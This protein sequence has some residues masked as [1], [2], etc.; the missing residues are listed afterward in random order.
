MRKKYFFR[1]FFLVIILVSNGIGSGVQSRKNELKGKLKFSDWVR[2]SKE[3]QQ[4]LFLRFNFPEIIGND[5]TLQYKTEIFDEFTIYTVGCFTKTNKKKKPGFEDVVFTVTVF[6]DI[7]TARESV[8][9]LLSTFSAPIEYLDKEWKDEKASHGDKAFGKNLWCM[10]NAVIRRGNRAYD[11]ALVASVFNRFENYFRRKSVS[12]D[13][14]ILP[15]QGNAGDGVITLD[16]FPDNSTVFITAPAE[17]DLTLGLGE[18]NRTLKI[19]DTDNK[20]TF[21]INDIHVNTVRVKE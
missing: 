21:N 11:E 17:Y 6:P 5:L 9:D 13:M 18:Q 3:D 10:G 20:E 19:K 4:Y 8:I 12:K 7:E 16:A 1:V 14:D 15:L 2:S